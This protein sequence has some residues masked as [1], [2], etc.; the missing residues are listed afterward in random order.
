MAGFLLG[1]VGG[2]PLHAAA[3]FFVVGAHE[4]GHALVVRMVRAR[5]VAIDFHV[6]GGQCLWQG[7]VTPLRRCG[8][9][10]GGALAQLGIFAVVIAVGAAFEPPETTAFGALLAAT[11]L[12]NLAVL[13]FN[14]LPARGL[15][16]GEAWKIV[17]LLWERIR[18]PRRGPP[19][20]TLH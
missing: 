4:L 8:I 13:F 19:R 5:V 18:R 16:G 15:D 1:A 12:L 6:F 14:L 20:P 9:A 7:S 11:F 10:W 2:A 3:F 17:P